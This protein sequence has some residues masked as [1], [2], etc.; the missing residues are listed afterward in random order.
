MDIRSLNTINSLDLHL[1]STNLSIIQRGV[2]YSGCKAFN[3]LPA[4]IKR[5]SE[6]PQHFK[7]VLKKYLM[8]QSIYS[9]EEY[10][11]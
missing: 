1:P 9:L 5:N 8:D 4:D 10:Y 2:L 11:C 6:N 7:K 3:N